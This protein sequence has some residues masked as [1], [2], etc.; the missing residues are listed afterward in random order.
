MEIFLLKVVFMQ[1]GCIREEVDVLGQS[2]CI[3]AKMV[4]L[5]Q[6][7]LYSG[8]SGCIWAK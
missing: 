3:P 8:R 5:K 1:S 4:V 2:C 6:K 7:W